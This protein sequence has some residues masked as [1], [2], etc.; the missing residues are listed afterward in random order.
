MPKA[1]LR[2]I[3]MPSVIISISQFKIDIVNDQGKAK[4]CKWN[5][6][7]DENGLKH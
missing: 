6:T 2:N 3:D 5:Q 4:G 1:T 7:P